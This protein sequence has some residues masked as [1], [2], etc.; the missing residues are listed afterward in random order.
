MSFF[1]NLTSAQ[2]LIWVILVLGFFWAMEG[3]YPLFSFQQNKWKHAS[4]NLALLLSTIVINA[5]FGVLTLGIFQWIHNNEIGLL[6]LIDWPLTVEIILGIM[7]LDLIAQYGVHYLLHKVSP[8]W[9]FHMVHHSDIQVDA[10]TG[11]RHHPGDYIFREL[12]ALI[13]VVI[14]GIPLG[15]YLLYRIITVFCTY[16]THA[17]LRISPRLDR[18]ISWIFISPNMHKFHHHYER[19][20]TDSNYGNIFSFWDRL[21]GT[22]VYEDMDKIHYG[23][24]VLENNN[25]NGLRRQ[26]LLP[27]DK[28]IKTDY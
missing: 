28:S 23:L 8:L 11:T 6:H 18:I 14:G 12:F 17:N 26:L 7:L 21:F 16:F 15:V 5:L 24:D 2:K 27:F 1:E 4:T 9:R 10:T 20:W 3:I 25:S 22:F 13:A 19:P